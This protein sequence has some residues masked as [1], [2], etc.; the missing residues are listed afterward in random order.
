M[1]ALVGAEATT[2]DEAPRRIGVEVKRLAYLYM[3]ITIASGA[4]VFSEPAP[5][6]A[7]MVGAMLMLPVVGLVRFTKGISL[8][9]ALWTSIVA[10]GFVAT[11]Q[12]GIF[13]VAREAAT[14]GELGSTPKNRASSA[15]VA[16]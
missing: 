14:I 4:V 15:C 11:A 13:D 2:F 10:G 12:A 6:D 16:R 7:L 8:Y 9:L 1:T 3:W 5:Y